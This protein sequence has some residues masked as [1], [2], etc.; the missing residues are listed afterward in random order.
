ME[1]PAPDPNGLTLA[2]A[3]RPE[4]ADTASRRIDTGPT[5]CDGGRMTPEDQQPLAGPVRVVWSQEMLAYDFGQGH[6][7]TSER[8]DL[9][10]RLAQDLGL[11]DGPGVE[12]VD[13]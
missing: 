12:L 1:P 10:I 5:G 2:C 9:T 13:A 4:R 7:M 3:R 6:P 8:L 11:L